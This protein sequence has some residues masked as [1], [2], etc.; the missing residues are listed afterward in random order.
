MKE[1]G[2][3]IDCL[4]PYAFGPIHGIKVFKNA[5]VY[6]RLPNYWW[7]WVKHLLGQCHALSGALWLR[8]LFG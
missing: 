8:K 1:W 7:D 2:A 5:G 4:E 3:I 6:M